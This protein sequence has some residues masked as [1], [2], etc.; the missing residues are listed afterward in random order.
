MERGQR[1]LLGLK[2]TG[3]AK[4]GRIAFLSAGVHH[5]DVSLEVAR[6]EGPAAVKGA[7]GLYHIAFCVGASRDDLETTRREVERALTMVDGVIE[8]KPD[9]AVLAFGMA[10][11]R[12][13]IMLLFPPIPM[14]AWLF[15]TLYGLLELYLGIS[16][17][18]PDV[19]QI[20][21]A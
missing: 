12:R 16:G 3:R 8:A 15:V 13:R 14:P 19:A 5:H 2:E 21:P 20:Q 1:D 9:L 4:G 6:T 7:P 17:R 10:F 11:P 18:Q